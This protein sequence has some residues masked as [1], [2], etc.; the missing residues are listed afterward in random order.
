M[1]TLYKDIINYVLNNSVP[2]LLTGSLLFL[3]AQLFYLENDI[4]RIQKRKRR[5]L[6]EDNVNKIKTKWMTN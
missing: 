3:G 1:E 2:I 5:S 4:S 6:L